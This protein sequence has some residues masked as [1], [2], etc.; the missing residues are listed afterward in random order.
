[1]QQFAIMHLI[2]PANWALPGWLDHIRPRLAIETTP[3]APQLIRRMGRTRRAHL[4]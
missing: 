3:E 1:V 4:E 2:G